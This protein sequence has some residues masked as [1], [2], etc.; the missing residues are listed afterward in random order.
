MNK[1]INKIT[2]LS[3]FYKIL[4]ELTLKI[5]TVNIS[6]L[7]F[8]LIILIFSAL[9]EVSLL[10]L[11]F[12]LIKAFMDPNY[13]Q[14]NF[15][16]KFFLNIFEI[17][18]NSQL[19]IYLS[20][21]FIL[22]SFTAGFFRVG[23]FYLLY[24]Y[25]YFFGKNVTSMCYQKV[26]YE[27]YSNLYQKNTN[28]TL[29]IFNK[30]PI[31]NNSFFTTL[32]MIYNLVTFIFIFAILAYINFQITVISS[33]FFIFLYLSV[34]L[35]FKKKIFNNA[36]IISNE[37]AT[38]IKI[39]RETFNGFRDILINNYQ[40]F[41]NNLFLK[42]YS[43]LSRGG[44]ENR[45][46]YTAP[47]PIIET[48]LLVGIGVVISLN[49]NNY[50]SLENL[51]PNIAVLAVASQRILPI[52]NQ[53]YAGHMSNVDA[54]PHIM[55]IF[56]FLKKP[57]K[58]KN[59]KNLKKIQFKD[60]ISLKN[61]S[62]SYNSSSKLVLKNI[63]L[64][65]SAGSRIG[66]I[67]KSGSGKSTLADLILG[68]LNPNSGE[69]SVDRK[70]IINLKESW[71]SCVASVPQNIFITEQTISENIAF[72]VNKSKINM[73]EVK[74][75]SSKAEL[76][77]FIE[78][79]ENRYNNIIGEKGLKISAGQRQRLAIARALYKKS[80]LIIF[81]EAT[82]SLDSESEKNVLNTIF[83]L[84]RKRHTLIIITHKLSNLKRCDHIYK[85]QN[86]K[87]IKFK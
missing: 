78:N 56:N 9:F 25:V 71:F 41:Y 69:I 74:K 32:L 11:L 52:L 33:L 34:I 46:F 86:S 63:N 42:S 65:I 19:V 57:L 39:V 58:I 24:R 31:V 26:I 70:P 14:G 22:A 48:F 79:R 60:K 67:G 12:V 53:L 73:E 4:Y 72:G 37:Q 68:L 35:L 20:F 8:F 28:D 15:L 66:I 7:I 81:D 1:I 29:S 59:K 10:G 80:K 18:S 40:K 43:S 75:S 76:S 3:N 55:F 30:M 44:E 61:V 45:F 6:Y 77:D 49:S 87:I 85:I 5:K 64:I 21:F 84:S 13:Y 2:S 38:N 47:K 54:T 82:S 62:F 50:S 17:R 83:S 27:D 23:F 51:L 16:F 36:T